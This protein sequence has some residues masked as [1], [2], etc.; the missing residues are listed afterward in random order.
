[1]VPNSAGGYAWEVDDMRRLRRFMCLGSE[2]GTYYIGEK[3]L[4]K[5]NAAAI[6]RLISS[7]KGVDVVREIVQFSVEGRAAKQDPIVFALALCARD[8]DSAT[9]AAAYEALN[10]VCRIPTHLFAFVEFCQSLSEGTGWGRAHRTAIQKWY[11][12]KSPK[13]LAQAVTK[14]KQRNGWSHLDVLRLCHL[15]PETD[16][17]ACVCKYVVK[18]IEACRA[19]FSGKADVEKNNKISGRCG[20]SKTADEATM[21]SLI[22]EHKL[23]RE[24]IPTE[25]L[26]SE[27]VW[28]ALLENMPMTAMIRNLGKMSS[29]GLLKPLSSHSEVVCQR[30]IDTKLLQDARIHPFNVLL[31]LKTYEQGKG[32]KGK[33]TWEV[34]QSI[35]SALDKAYYLSFKFVEPTGKRY[36]LAID[37]SGSMT[38]YKVLGAN[39]IDA[40]TASAAMAMVTARTESKYQMV[41]FSHE[42]VPLSINASM[43]LNTVMSKIGAVPMGGTDCA[44]PMLYAMK[45]KLEVDVFIVYT[46]CETWAGAN[47]SLSGPQAVQKSIW[48][49]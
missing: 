8:K 34:N 33:L 43:D 48:H 42:L 2:G 28:A 12:S 24:H 4:G 7:G 5:E 38:S 46:D 27:A 29:I 20:S 18:G 45:K 47:P 17:I 44:Q 1:M 6:I 30:L 22:E 39:T 19:E 11:S 41:G 35:V 40:R 31:A 37:V 32:D 36:L 26:N 16:G 21:I 9:K 14:Y 10:K 3:K 13:A 49:F 23:V 25:L 15:K